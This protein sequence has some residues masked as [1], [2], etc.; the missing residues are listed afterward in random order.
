MTRYAHLLSRALVAWFVAGGLVAQDLPPVD[1]FALEA[2]LEAEIAALSALRWVPAASVST[3]IGWRDN[4]LLSS[5]APVSRAFARGEVEAILW[6]PQRHPWEFVSFLNGDVLRYFSAPPETAGEQQWVMDTEIRWEPVEP[7]R[8]ALKAVGYWQDAVIDLS[9]TEAVRLVAAT[10]VRGGFVAFEPRLTLPA[11]FQLEPMVQLRRNGYR[12]YT[13]DYDELTGGARIAWEH[14]NSLALSAAWYDLRRDYDQRETF[15]MGGRPLS[16][17][18][19]HFR[20]REGEVKVRATW[21]TGGEW[22][23]EATAGRMENRDRASGYFDYNQERAALDLTWEAGEWIVSLAAEGRRTEFR[24]Q[25]VGAGISPPARLAEDFAILL[26]T[27]RTI[28]ARWTAFAEYRWERGRSNL[29]D[30]SYRVNTVLAGIER[31]F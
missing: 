29:T 23:L 13:G 30:F 8:L 9:E 20:Q 24:T 11:G 2:A 17:T 16:G 26:R 21:L 1:D 25:T 4:V 5:F 18:R 28:N 22:T 19:L 7:L 27:E 3:S 15:T 10:R 14:S 12:D 6:R 31:R